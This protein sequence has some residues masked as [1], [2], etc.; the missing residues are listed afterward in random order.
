MATCQM[1]G[2]EFDAFAPD[3]ARGM[4]K[5]CS[6]DCYYAFES[7]SGHEKYTRAVGGKRSDL[8]SR[9]FRSMWEANYARYLNWLVGQGEIVGWEYEVDTFEFGKIKRGQRFYTPDF[10]IA[11]RDGSTE[12]H[13]VKGWMDQASKT[14]MDRMARYYPNIKVLIIDQECYYAIA[15]VMKPMLPEWETKRK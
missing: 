13:E 6:R 7:T 12:Y 5:F 10:K 3:V 14:K 8:D 2:N 11:N 9:Y 4:G 1:C 15:K